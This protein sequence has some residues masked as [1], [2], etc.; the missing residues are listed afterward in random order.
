MNYT[1]IIILVV[2]IVL[3]IFGIY[4]VR[5]TG[6]VINV[7][8]DIKTNYAVGEK[9][10]GSLLLEIQPGD[11]IQKDTLISIDIQLSKNGNVLQSSNISFA[12]FLAGQVSPVVMLNHVT[13]CENSSVGGSEDCVNQTVEN[14]ELVCENVSVDSVVQSC[15]EGVDENNNSVENCVNNTVTNIVP[16]CTT[17]DVSSVVENCSDSGSGSEI[18]QNCSDH[19]IT[20]YY[21]NQTGS[22]SNDLENFINYT[23]IEPGEYELAVNIPS[24][25]INSQKII[26]VGGSQLSI[27]TTGICP[28]GMSGSGTTVDPCMV[29]D[30]YTLQNM[31]LNLGYSYALGNNIDCS[32]TSTWNGG[33]G[34]VPV[35][36]YDLFVADKFSGNFDGRNHTISNLYMQG[37]DNLALFGD[38]RGSN[39]SNVG[40]VNVSIIG[41]HWYM[42]GL[43]AHLEVNANIFNSYSTGNV[44]GL[45]EVGGLVAE[46]SNSI[47]FNSYS[48]VNVNGST[49]GGLV[50][51]NDLGGIINNSYSTGNVTGGSDVGGLAGECYLGGT[52]SNSYSTGNVSGTNIGGLVGDYST[53]PGPITNSYWYNQSQGLSCYSGGNSGCIANTTLSY[54]YSNHFGWDNVSVWNFKGAAYPHLVWESFVSP[55]T[56]SGTVNDPYMINNCNQLQNMS[57]NLAASYALKGN[58]DCS[59]TSSW[60]I[61][62]NCPTYT[63]QTNCSAASGCSWVGTGVSCILS[64]ILGGTCNY[65]VNIP[66]F[67]SIGNVTNPF[68]GNLNGRGFNITSFSGRSLFKDLNGSASNL[69]FINAS[70]FGSVLAGNIFPNVSVFNC[71]ARGNVDGNLSYNDFSLYPYPPIGVNNVCNGD[72]EMLG[73]LVPNGNQMGGLVGI[74][75][76]NLSYS[77][78]IGSIKNGDDQV[79]GLVGLSRGYIQNSYAITNVSG[80]SDVGGLVG[81]LQGNLTNSYAIANVK[82]TYHSGGLVGLAFRSISNCYST[83]TVFG[84]NDAG[85]LVGV[86]SS[87]IGSISNSFSTSNITSGSYKSGITG[88]MNCGNGPQIKNSS[89]YNMSNGLNCYDNGNLGCTPETSLNYFY[90]NNFGW[91]GNWSFGNGVYP[92]LSSENYAFPQCINNACGTAVDGSGN[93]YQCGIIN[94]SGNYVLNQSIIHTATTQEDSSGNG[95]CL[96][97]SADNIILDGNGYNISTNGTAGVLT[98]GDIGSSVYPVYVSSVNNITIKNSKINSCTNGVYFSSNSTNILITNNSFGPQ[99]SC[100]SPGKA[101]VFN[102]LQNSL[103][104]NNSGLCYF[105][106]AIRIDNGISNV[107]SNN[108]FSLAPCQVIISSSSSGIYFTLTSSNNLISNNVFYN[109]S[110]GI[111]FGFNESSDVLSNNSIVLYTDS[112]IKSFELLSVDPLPVCSWQTVCNGDSCGM[113]EVCSSTIYPNGFNNLTLIDQKIGKYNINNFSSINFVNSSAGSILLNGIIG[114]GTNLFGN[115]TSDVKIGNNFAYVNSSA[116]NGGLNVGGSVTLYNVQINNEPG[117]LRDGVNCGVSCSNAVKSGNNVTFSVSGWSNYTVV[118]QSAIQLNSGWNLISLPMKNTSVGTDRNITIVGD[119]VNGAWTLIGYGSSVPFEL[120]NSIF[121]NSS[122]VALNWSDAVDA[123]EIQGYVAYYDSNESL[124]NA[125]KYKYV[126]GSDLGM[127]QQNLTNKLGYWVYSYEDGTLT[128]PKVGGTLMGQNYSWSNLR[129]SNGTSELNV[130]QAATN[131]W[132]SLTLY[133]WGYSEGEQAYDF[134]PITGQAGNTINSW[135]GIFINSTRDNITL[136][137]NN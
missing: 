13:E 107:I 124:A 129:F 52:V 38:A 80:Y 92:H 39:I 56:G 119:P 70:T 9:L 91:D 120:N 35:G 121:T 74:N 17:E 29:T 88:I 15:S 93:V 109:Y 108:N 78:F 106:H 50:G 4:Y 53:L 14:S 11:L 7:S 21:F 72:W 69:Y 81:N 67:V 113:Q 99:A 10:N 44:N 132:I 26:D 36:M 23:F 116:A 105:A 100:T 54:F 87:M 127:Q 22:Y 68:S 103:I 47:I 133:N 62:A 77:Y 125:R 43:A 6:H 71:G 30:C 63:D 27:M 90:S 37:T 97:I 126:S 79:G 65:C 115:S 94:V 114:N 12:D 122:G 40:M 123:G 111:K 20:D 66:G 32:M 128:L 18:I 104:S 130:T 58:I 19:L 49:V 84:V 136:I 110:G 83:G 51:I 101:L 86:G 59:A 46:N 131:G 98:N 45:D 16:N 42:A 73:D 3:I 82:G 1:G 24:L 134:I 137:R 112:F 41:S 2:L 25:N 96:Y 117:I 89:W 8:S 48:T 5:F 102:N 64:Q 28:G 57:L 85:G 61:N 60:R 75:Q 55:F 76:G 135:Q 95:S 33:A 31:S 118:D 34:F